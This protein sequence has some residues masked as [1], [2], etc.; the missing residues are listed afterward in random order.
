MILERAIPTALLRRLFDTTEHPQLARRLRLAL[1]I[2]LFAVLILAT[3]AAALTAYFE[4][5]KT[6]D[7]TLLSIGHLVETNQIGTITDDDVFDDDDFDD[8]AVRIWEFGRE[9]RRSIRVRR[10]LREGF[11][12]VHEGDDFWRLYITRPNRSGQRFTVAQKRSVSA[13]LA[14]NSAW[15][16]ALP[17]IVLFLFTP[18]LVTWIVRHSFKPLNA[19]ANEVEQSDSL[20]LDFD[21]R[22]TIPAELLPFIDAI[23]NLLDKNAAFNARQ[24]RFIA[25]AAH[26][27]RTPITALSLQIENV[28]SA[29]DGNQ[30]AE[31]E[32]LLAHSVQRLQR[33][34]GQLLD[35][36]RVQSSDHPALHVTRLD[37]LI[38]EQISEFIPLAE[39]KDIAL[40]VSQLDALS[41]QDN[42][43]QLQH[44]VRNALSNAIK[45]APNGGE[46]DLAL[47]RDGS[48][49]VFSVTDNG[50]GVPEH[51]LARLHE[52]FFRTDE[53]ASGLGA[54]LGL[55][56]CIEIAER[57]NGTLALS[58]VEPTGFRFEARLPVSS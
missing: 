42:H 49:A 6:Q 38:K 50:P 24:R 46:V 19:L 52:P 43:H 23:D 13:E 5:S 55:A 22:D 58:N 14:G 44:L 37:D 53:H 8:S 17:L 1:F 20:Q 34:V 35:L 25:D 27:L 28:Q 12:T 39:Q 56:I 29:R 4:A 11:H 33:L 18:V 47:H 51:T 3:I 7:E 41:V 40:G 30:K 57:H 21:N 48:N 15:N 26:E 16:T 2:T 45:F 36:A 32:A 9:T 54:G 31:R 10:T